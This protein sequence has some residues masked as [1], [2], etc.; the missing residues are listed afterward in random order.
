MQIIFK[1]IKTCVPRETVFT[2][3]TWNNFCRYNHKDVSKLGF[4]NCHYN[5]VRQNGVIFSAGKFFTIL[6]EKGRFPNKNNFLLYVLK[7]IK[8]AIM[9][10]DKRKNYEKVGNLRN[11]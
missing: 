2:R 7:V 5:A 11:K 6:Y 9:F 4:K 8:T 1:I 10:T 3:F